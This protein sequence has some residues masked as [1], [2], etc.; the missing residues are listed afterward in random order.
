VTDL[1]RDR[2]LTTHTG[3]LPRSAALLSWVTTSRPDEK[4]T[5]M[6][7]RV[8]SPVRDVVQQ[9]VDAGIDLVNDGEVSKVSYMTYPIE[10]MSGFGG[11]ASMGEVTGWMDVAL[12]DFPDFAERLA[13]AMVAASGIRY[14]ACDG[15]ISYTGQSELQADIA[16]LQKATADAY[17]TGVFMNSGS[18]GLIARFSPN[19]HYGSEEEYLTAIAE[20]MRTE[21]EAIHRA[22]FILQVDCPDLAMGVPSFEPTKIRRY[23]QKRI[24]ALNYALADIPAESVRMHVCWGSGELP[25]TTDIELKDIIDVLLTAKPAGLMLM[26]SNG[27]HAHEWQVFGDRRLPEGKYLVPGVIDSAS[28]VVEHPDTVAQRI[29]QYAHVVGRE[30]IVAGTDC[31]FSPVAGME[32]VAPTVVRAKL[33]TLAEGARRASAI[34]WR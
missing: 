4:S 27:R 10:R 6:E 22:G 12:A 16:R 30:N 32:P 13:S 25:R 1:V 24:E 9:Q 18:P 23:L 14:A 15:P 7:N 17:P 26:A 8:F 19:L 34:L 2:V 33:G 31:G 5:D 21:Y 28:N 20:A 29:I 11:I 3:S